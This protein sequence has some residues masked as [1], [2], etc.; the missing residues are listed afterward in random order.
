[1]TFSPHPR[2][3]DEK[4]A[5]H[6]DVLKDFGFFDVNNAI[7]GAMTAIANQAT[8]SQPSSMS[9]EQYQR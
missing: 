9:F 8:S 4:S 6:E 2:S 7:V 1:M 3:L 5:P